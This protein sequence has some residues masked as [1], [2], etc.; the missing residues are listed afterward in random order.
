MKEIDLKAVYEVLSLI[1]PVLAGLIVGLILGRILTRDRPIIGLLEERLGKADE[2]LAQFSHQLKVQNEEIKQQQL[3][4]QR[5]REAAAVSHAQ[6][7]AVRKERD[8][9]KSTQ[10][11]TTV[12]LEK[13]RIEKETLGKQAAE[14]AE[15]LR[16]QEG[17]TQFL[18]KARADLITRICPSTLCTARSTTP[19]LSLDPTGL[20]SIDALHQRQRCKYS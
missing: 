10:A 5:A 19:L 18:E 12:T 13:I 11:N 4:L 16:S 17:Q 2:G 1:S 3:Q 15:K 8:D 9:L 14:A 7:E 6:L 20:F